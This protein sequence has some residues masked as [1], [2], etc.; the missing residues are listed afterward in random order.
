MSLVKN[1]L[2]NSGD[3]RDMGS[4]LGLGDPMEKGMATHSSILAWEV[5]WSEES[6]RLQSIGSQSQT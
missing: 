1:L 3:I 2:A 6:G 5:R 4:V